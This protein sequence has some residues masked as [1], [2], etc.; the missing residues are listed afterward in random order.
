MFNQVYDA[1]YVYA[2]HAELLGN[3]RNAVF[4]FTKAS[5]FANDISVG[6]RPSR[7]VLDQTHEELILT[8]RLGND[9]RYA[10][11]AECNEGFDPSLAANKVEL[12]AIW[13]R[14]LAPH[15]S[16]R[17]LQSN[18]S[19]IGNDHLPTEAASWPWIGDMDLRNGNE[20][21]ELFRHAAPS[22]RAR[23]AISRKKLRL[24]KR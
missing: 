12:F 6:R 8:G 19:D 13:I 20:L 23:S 1:S 14:F 17:L 11:F 18:F 2:F 22:I 9:R 24:V 5:D 4:A 15:D 10:G 7:D 21:D 3:I 16:D